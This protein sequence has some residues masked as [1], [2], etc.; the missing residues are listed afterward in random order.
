[1]VKSRECL[2]QRHLLGK[3][4]TACLH[5]V[6]QGEKVEDYDRIDSLN[7]LSVNLQQLFQNTAGKVILVLDSI[8][9]VKGAGS[10]M[11]PA[12]ARLADI[13]R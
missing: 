4:F 10:T 13:V 11:L 2:S 3:I 12:L 6:E 9:E 1:M 7:A 5:A 8:D